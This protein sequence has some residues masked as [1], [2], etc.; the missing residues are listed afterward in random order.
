MIPP[1]LYKYRSLASGCR[2]HTLALLERMEIYY[3]SPKELNDPMEFKSKLEVSIPSIEHVDWNDTS[4]P[5][6]HDVR[7]EIEMSKSS[8]GICCFSECPRSHLM[9]SHYA[10]SHRGICVGFDTQSDSGWNNAVRIEYSDELP[11]FR[12]AYPFKATREHLRYQQT[13]LTDWK[14]EK[15]W[16]FIRTDLNETPRKRQLPADAL[17]VII[18]GSKMSSNDRNQVIQIARRSVKQITLFDAAFIP[19]SYDMVL[20]PIKLI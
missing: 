9:W 19:D 4:N 10:D 12:I 3:A 1:L 13:K 6:V 2:E 5:L 14:Y 16:R 20:T 17:S 15:E 7:S 18:L 8:L 11:V